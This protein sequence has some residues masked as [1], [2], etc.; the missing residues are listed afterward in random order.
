MAKP[1]LVLEKAFQQRRHGSV[2][3]RKQK[4]PMFRPPHVVSSLEQALRQVAGFEIGLGAQQG[5]IQ[6]RD[7]DASHLMPR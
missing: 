6:A 1:G 3:E 4:E 5:K 2:P 7:L